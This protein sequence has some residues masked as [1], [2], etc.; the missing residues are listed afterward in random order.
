MLFIL[1]IQSFLVSY[2]SKYFKYQH[3]RNGAARR[4]FK[5]TLFYLM[6][7]NEKRF[8]KHKNVMIFTLSNNLVLH[9]SMEIVLFMKKGKTCLKYLL[10][11]FSY[12]IND[13]ELSA[14]F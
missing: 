6:Y 8:Y 13:K 3:F 10:L 7:D 9:V 2:K 12:L 11:R 14:G 1:I 4:K 5:N